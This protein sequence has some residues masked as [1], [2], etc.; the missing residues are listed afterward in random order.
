VHG[1]RKHFRQT[2]VTFETISLQVFTGLILFTQ[3]FCGTGVKKTD[4]QKRQSE[5]AQKKAG[6]IPYKIISATEEGIKKA[7]STMADGAL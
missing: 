5:S 4:N 2:S 3:P 7:A 6:T 1:F